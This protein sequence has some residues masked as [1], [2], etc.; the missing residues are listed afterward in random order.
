MGPV[1]RFL[2]Q[3]RERARARRAAEQAAIMRA[4]FHPRVWHVDPKDG[5]CEYCSAARHCPACRTLDAQIERA[6]DNYAEDALEWAES[7]FEVGAETWPDR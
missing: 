7:G 6:R 2:R 3:R 1:V 4:Y 5:C